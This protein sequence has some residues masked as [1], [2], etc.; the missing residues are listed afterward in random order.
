MFN[1]FLKQEGKNISFLTSLGK[2][3]FKTVL[4]WDP[5]EIFQGQIKDLEK[6]LNKHKNKVIIGYFSYDLGYEL[7]SIKK[8]AKDDLKLPKIHLAAYSNYKFGRKSKPKTEAKKINFKPEITKQ[9]YEKNYK[10]IQKHIQA[11][12]IYQINY[13]HR[14]K[15]K[16]DK[17]PRELFTQ[18]AAANPVEHL[19]YIETTEFQILSASPER[20]IKTKNSKIFTTPIKGTK[21]HGKG[22]KEELKNDPKEKAEL[23]MITDL[24]RNDLGKIARSG[25]VKVEGSRLLKKCPSVWHAYSRISAKLAASPIKALI[26]MMPGGSITGC[27]KRRAMQIIDEIEPTTRNIYCGAIG[28]I[29][30]EQEVI[31]FSIAIRTI[32]K[33][34]QDLYLQVG[35][36][37]VVDSKKDSE[38]NETLAKAK[39]FTK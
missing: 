38:Y 1:Q 27:P 9:Q 3:G 12:D 4:A 37:I 25:S 24:L 19:A 29:M 2:D 5:D 21:P 31:D 8:T 10:K 32:V 13:T 34:D 18:I 14:L 20:F 28:I 35:G 6:F 15:A 22:A 33:K 16:S 11:G 39:S 7:H 26:S 17:N 23:N 30:P 36:G